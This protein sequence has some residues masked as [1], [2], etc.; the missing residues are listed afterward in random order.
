MVYVYQSNFKN[1]N[2]TIVAALAGTFVLEECYLSELYSKAIDLS[3]YGYGYYNIFENC[4]L[5]SQTL[6]ISHTDLSF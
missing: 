1:I 2:T 5:G 6:F 4:A 3:T